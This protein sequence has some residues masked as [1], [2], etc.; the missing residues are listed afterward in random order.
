MYYPTAFAE[1][2]PDKVAF[3]L[4]GSGEEVTFRQLEERSNQAA[5]LFRACG[6]RHGDHIVIFIEHVDFDLFGLRQFRRFF[7]PLHT[8]G[9][10]TLD[11]CTGGFPFAIHGDHL[12]VD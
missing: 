6:L 11:A 1:A 12:L 2:T 8:Q 7:G 10:A 9:V 5:Q 3:K 4:L